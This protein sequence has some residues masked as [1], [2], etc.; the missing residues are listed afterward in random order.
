MSPAQTQHLYPE[1]SLL[2]AH[3]CQRSCP[4]LDCRVPPWH[5]LGTWAQECLPKKPKSP[6]SSRWALCAT[7]A[8]CPTT[9]CPRL[10]RL[11]V[12]WDPTCCIIL[13][14][15][16]W[17]TLH[18]FKQ[19]MVSNLRTVFKNALVFS[20]LLYFSNL[21]FYTWGK[22]KQTLYYL[23]PQF[24]ISSKFLVRI[25]SIHCVGP[26]YPKTICSLSVHLRHR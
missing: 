9:Q 18:H 19:E 3:L 16:R 6:S 24:Q 20:K 15:G 23:K 4:H 1:P 11:Q 14:P 17:D 7:I 26:I 10:L 2:S 12:R 25:H 5:C 8:F 22:E 13:R 21:R